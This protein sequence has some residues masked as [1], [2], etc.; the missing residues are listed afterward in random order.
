MDI[1]NG[2]LSF[3]VPLFLLLVYYWY[4]SIPVVALVIFGYIKTKNEGLKRALRIFLAFIILA[5]VGIL[6]MMISNG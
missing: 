3:F 2:F 5:V 6:I 4:I 1:L